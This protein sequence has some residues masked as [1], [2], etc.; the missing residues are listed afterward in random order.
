[1]ESE[2]E[3]E[4]YNTSEVDGGEE[5]DPDCWNYG[6]DHT[7]GY[8]YDGELYGQALAAPVIPY[9]RTRSRHAQSKPWSHNGD[10]FYPNRLDAP[11]IHFSGHKQGPSAYLKLE[12]D[13]EQLFIAW[14]IPEKLKP[15]YA[16]DT[17]IGEA[18]KWWSQLDADLIYFNDPAYTWIQVK[19]VMLFDWRLRLLVDSSVLLR[20]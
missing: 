16:I 19:M 3:A 12:D 20:G 4:E 8:C 17:L 15:T 2:E 13:M 7:E 5:A 11:S 1:M 14:R 18:Y 6:E 9:H 10:Q